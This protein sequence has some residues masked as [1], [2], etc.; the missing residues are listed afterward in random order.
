MSF[1]PKKRILVPVDFSKASFKAIEVASQ[2][3]DNPA[4]LHV[5]HVTQPLHVAEPGVL[6]GTVTDTTR[7]EMST[8]ALKEQVAAKGFHEVQVHT[9]LG[10]PA[11]VI[12]EVARET[13]AELIVIPSHGRSGLQR[14]FLGSVTEKVLRMAE[15]PVLVLRVTED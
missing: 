15:C 7:L 12:A 9:R 13:N 14:L 3:V 5:V 1:L 8:K 2:M 11:Q 6:W 4:G 10:L